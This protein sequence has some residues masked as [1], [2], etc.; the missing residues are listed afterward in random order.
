[1]FLAIAMDHSRAVALNENVVPRETSARKT[2]GRSES[3]EIFTRVFDA[4]RTILRTEKKS[5]MILFA[6]E[7]HRA[8]SRRVTQQDFVYVYC[9]NVRRLPQSSAEQRRSA[10][11]SEDRSVEQTRAKFYL[12][13]YREL[14]L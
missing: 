8:F 7:T 2:L 11:F 6:I 9:G 14:N 13:I 4:K 10:R 5:E 3:R 12:I 1:M